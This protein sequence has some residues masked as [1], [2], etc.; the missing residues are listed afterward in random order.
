MFWFVY[1][2][3]QVEGGK[4]GGKKIIRTSNCNVSG[5]NRK[6]EGLAIMCNYQA[7]FFYLPAFLLMLLEC[8]LISTDHTLLVVRK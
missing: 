5:L 7:G 8:L 6:V 2:L 4:S 1:I 3:E